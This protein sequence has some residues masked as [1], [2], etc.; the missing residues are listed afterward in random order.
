[1]SRAK[2]RGGDSDVM[3][4]YTTTY[5]SSYRRPN[6]TQSR[7]I[8]PGIYPQTQNIRT[9]F[10]SNNH[11]SPL[12]LAP[13]KD[14]SDYRNTSSH[15]THSLAAVNRNINRDRPVTRSVMERSG[16]WNE[17]EANILY[18]SPA[19]R[20]KTQQEREINAS[21][22]D[23][24]A[25]SRIS[26]Y[27]PI[28]AENHGAGPNWGSTTTGTAYSKKPTSYER[29]WDNGPPSVGRKEQNSFTRQHI[30]IP[31]DPVEE[32]ISIMKTSYCSR[33]RTR[34]TVGIP[35]NVTM[36]HSGFTDSIKPTHEK[37]LPLSNV[38]AEQL[39]PIT[40]RE[41]KLK[42]TTEYQNLFDP[43]PYKSV[44]MISYQ[45]PKRAVTAMAPKRNSG[46]NS[47][48]T[49][50]A[51]VPGDTRTFKTGNT[52]Y[53]KSFKEQSAYRTRDSSPVIPTVMER[54]GYWGN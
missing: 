3:S 41:L 44:S 15:E 24:L 8:T 29:L 32:P 28:D 21:H 35:S 11:I 1:M 48:E 9:G 18:E 27:N 7:S 31:E 22:L 43:D 39:P 14:R 49:V 17:P 19:M 46:Y 53:T 37:T 6:T 47:N 20:I 45:P 13:L 54:S 12:D 36:Q 2:S 25:L 50:R 30:T 5:A 33:P 51:G 52:T 4:F 23:R 42:N 26:H 34:S 38:T 16:Y 10:S 40:V